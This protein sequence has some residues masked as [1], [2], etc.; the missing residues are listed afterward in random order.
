MILKGYLKAGEQMLHSLSIKN[1]GLFK[2][3]NVD[4]DSNFSTITGESGT[5]KSMFLNALR[6][7]LTGNVPQNLKNLNGSVSAFFTVNDFIAEMVE[8][9]VPLENNELILAVNFTPKKTLFR[10]NDTIVPKNIVQEI[11]KYLLEVH[12]QDSNIALRDDN[13]QNSLIFK[14]LR[15]KFPNFFIEYDEVY[16]E[17]LN[18]KRKFENLPTDKTDIFRNIDILNYQIKEIE[19]ANFKPNEDDELSSRFKTLNNIEEIR[20]KLIESLYLLKEDD[21]SIDLQ[22]GEVVYNL[23]KII[24]YGFKEEHSLALFIQEQLTELFDLL[25]IK[26]ENLESDPE[27]L[28]R[29]SNRLNIIMELKRKY[30]PSLEDVLTNL[31]KYKSQK[32]MLEEI[33][34]DFHELEPKLNQLK[35]KLMNLSDNLIDQTKPFLD[36]LKKNVEENLK[37][38]NMENCKI[39]WKIK[40]LN[41]PQKDAAHKIVFLL[42]TNPKSDFLPLAE[43]ASGGE[44][45]RII[46]ALE[47]VLGKNHPIDTMVFDEIDSGV[48][49]RMADIVG[50]KLSDLSQNKQI[51]VITHMPQVATLANEHFK[52]IKSVDNEAISAIIKLSEK[53]KLNE[54]KEMYGNIVY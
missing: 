29:I 17:Y 49:P 27:E 7:F 44:L 30:G 46:L 8:D 24:D 22:I 10:L 43:V 54:I 32:N 1:F 42:K 47:I 9:Y 15:E 50:K 34:K 33:K 16:Q 18:L 45:S 21:K 53:E 39:D 12:S 37:D 23:S 2:K 3:A 36:V 31:E 28:E 41:A 26:V 6:I 13:Y 4:F 25:Q 19:E 38:L 52:I 14:I 51:I 40:K 35:N 20:E 48:G 5:G 11:S